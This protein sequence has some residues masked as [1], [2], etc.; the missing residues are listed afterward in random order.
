MSGRRTRESFMEAAD[1]F[2][3]LERK[4]DEVP[5]KGLRDIGEEIMADVKASRHGKGVPVDEGTLRSSGTV[6]G[7]DSDGAVRLT[8]GGPSAPY[9]LV[10]HERT[11]YSHTV[12]E[13]RYLIRGME[14]WQ[15]DGS[16][17]VAAMRANTIQ[18]IARS[19]NITTGVSAVSAPRAPSIESL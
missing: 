4:M 10:Q 17:A 3:E 8:F 5:E 12:G 14:R 7:P 16:A 9:A 15:P 2:R 19:G 6:R 1:A 13:S 18:A 11:D